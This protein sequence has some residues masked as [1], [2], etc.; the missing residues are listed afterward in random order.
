MNVK[1]VVLCM[2]ELETL[3]YFSIQIAKAAE[4]MNIE[5]YTI[6]TKHPETYSGRD[7]DEFTSKGE[8]IAILFNQVGIL[9]T[10]ENGENYWDNK[11]IPV[12]SM[13]VDHPRNFA[14]ALTNPIKELRVLSVD[15][16]H[17]DFI[18]SY[19]PAVSKVYFLPQAGAIEYEKHNLLNIK[20]R[21][22][23]IL[24]TGSCHPK[25]DSFPPI[26]G[27]PQSGMEMYEFAISL[28]LNDPSYTTEE[29]IAL[30]FISNNYSLPADQMLTI[31]T[32][33]SIYIESYVRREWKFRII[34]ALDKAGLQ[35]E[36]Y[37]EHWVAADHSLSKNICIHPRITSAECN[38]LMGKAKFTLNFLPWFKDGTS[39]R[40]FNTMLNGSIC[41]I[42]KSGYMTER[43]TDEKEL[44]F[45]DLSDADALV[46]KIRK[47]I[48]DPVAMQQIADN[49]Y[50]TAL[51]NDTWKN[52]LERIINFE[53]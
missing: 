51:A 16:K 2:G 49:G 21:P 44:I 42:D 40:P 1:R 3:D 6:H 14:D 24:Y 9:L 7:L 45:F 26:G 8:C 50:D 39:E 46:S 18:R 17:I 5:T 22:I 23:D 31:F 25:I 52:R 20:D 28:M 12:F 19:Y 38:Q 35:V 36:I 15:K 11:H 48:N 37:G 41:L 33:V 29:A 53:N 32:N 27:L 4:E 43:F 47:Y 10:A 34:E 13:Q 30:Y